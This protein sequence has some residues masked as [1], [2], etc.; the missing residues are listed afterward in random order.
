MIPTCLQVRDAVLS[1]EI[2]PRLYEVATGVDA[3]FRSVTRRSSS[4]VTRALAER[5]VAD[6]YK[7]GLTVTGLV[8]A[9]VVALKLNGHEQDLLFEM[10]WSDVSNE[11][12]SLSIRYSQ[13]MT[14]LI[15][16]VKAEVLVWHRNESSFVDGKMT[17][18][19]RIL[20][21]GAIPL[22][23]AWPRFATQGYRVYPP[24]SRRFVAK[25]IER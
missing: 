17:T 16:G 14:T 12:F 2:N 13:G 24:P 19:S 22:S 10:V 15:P 9:E 5:R 20:F 7:E 25:A 8:H 3:S 21:P 11:T 18:V 23:F 4:P 1:T 6:V